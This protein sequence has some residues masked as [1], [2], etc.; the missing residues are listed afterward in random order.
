MGQSLSDS[1]GTY[2]SDP[3]N[4]ADGPTAREWRTP[5][6]W[7]YRDSGPYLHDG[8]AQNLEE[9]VALHEGQ[10]TAA[11]HR[12]FALSS[13]G[14]ARVEAFLKSLVA[15]SS[16]SASGAV[17]AAD[18]ASLSVEDDDP[19]PE[20]VLRQ[21]RDRAVA[22]DEQQ[23]QGAQREIRLAAASR[24]TRV[25][26]RLAQKLERIGKTKG[27]LAFYQEIARDACGTAEGSAAAERISALSTQT[28]SP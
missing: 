6:L 20:S 21:Q 27:A 1:G 10:G 24:R 11:A 9:A 5:P 26:I 18:A 16:A 28:A 3:R 22:Q 13:Q 8:R 12:F 23:W 25:Q 14:Q 2:G 19:A 17:L 4:V 7:G 15:P